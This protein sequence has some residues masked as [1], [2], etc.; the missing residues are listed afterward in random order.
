MTCRFCNQWKSFRFTSL[1]FI[2]IFFKDLIIVLELNQSC[3]GDQNGIRNIRS[4][5]NFTVFESIWSNRGL[6]STANFH[7]LHTSWNLVK[8]SKGSQ[9]VNVFCKI[10]VS[11]TCLGVLSMPR[12]NI[13]F[14]KDWNSC[15]VSPTCFNRTKNSSREP[16]SFK[17][18]KTLSNSKVK[19]IYFTIVFL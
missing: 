9:N 5:I 19:R 2:S 6:V 13:I 4:L 18:L 8:H 1:S 10:V 16:S 7:D 12:D 11:Q 3:C 17:I 14:D 15:E